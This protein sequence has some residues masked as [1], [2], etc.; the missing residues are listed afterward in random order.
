MYTS[1]RLQNFLADEMNVGIASVVIDR[2]VEHRNAA[3][4]D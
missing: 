2:C 4:N 1:R 3:A